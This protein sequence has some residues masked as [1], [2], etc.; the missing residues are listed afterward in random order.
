MRMFSQQYSERTVYSV[1]NDTFIRKA[2]IHNVMPST[3]VSVD[4]ISIALK[5]PNNLFVKLQ[6]YAV[7]LYVNK[8]D[9]TIVVIYHQQTKKE[10]RNRAEL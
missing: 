2:R 1:L 4:N 9:N 3:S 7:N 5:C 6:F 8:M 10:E